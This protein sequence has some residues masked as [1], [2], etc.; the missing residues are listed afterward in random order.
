MTKQKTVKFGVGLIALAF[1]SVALAAPVSAWGPAR[2]TYTMK[3][4]A[5]HAVFNSITDNAAVGDERNFVRIAEIGSGKPYGDNVEVSAG[6]RYSVYIYYH[7]DA[8]ATYN[9]AEYDH[10]GW[11]KNTRMSSKFPA[12]LKAGEKGTVTGK[13]TSTS[14]DPASVW[15]EAFMTAKEDVTLHYIASSAR[16]YN[17]WGANGGGLSTNLF[18]STGTFI[19]TNDLDGFVPG[20]DEYSGQVIYTILAKAVEKEPEPEDPKPEEPEDPKPEDPV[21]PVDP[22]DPEEPQPEI[23]VVPIEPEEVPKELPSTGP[24][25]IMLAVVV[26][27]AIVAGGVYWWKTHKA[28]KKATKRAKGKK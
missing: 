26:V 13:I 7:N 3:K 19:G 11:A 5:D 12:S 28:V 21:I 22:E 10:R 20:C 18:S 27:L 6:K 2:T 25:E 4:P 15:D 14:T 1:V 9:E 8:S 23:P 16:I 24:A 17:G